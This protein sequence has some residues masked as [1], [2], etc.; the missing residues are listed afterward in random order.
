MY[1]C[2]PDENG[3]IGNEDLIAVLVMGGISRE[4][5]NK[6]FRVLN[7]YT[8]PADILKLPKD[9]R[10]VIG[11]YP[12]FITKDI[13]AVSADDEEPEPNEYVPSPE[14]ETSQ[15]KQEQRV[16][17]QSQYLYFGI[18]FSMRSGLAK[19]DCNSTHLELDVNADGLKAF[20]KGNATFWP[21]L[22]QFGDNY[23]IFIITLYYGTGKPK[24][25]D[26]YLEDFV[27]E[28]EAF[29]LNKGVLIG[30]KRY[31]ISFRWGIFDTPARCFIL[32]VPYY[33]SKKDGCYLCDVKG[34]SLNRR[35][36][37][38]EINSN[39]RTAEDP[40][41]QRDNNPLSKIM[42]IDQTKNIPLDGMHLAE[43]GLM[44]KLTA[45]WYVIGFIFN[46]L[47]SV[48]AQLAR[49]LNKLSEYTPREFNRRISSLDY[50][51]QF[52]SKEFRMLL[53]YM[54][55][56]IFIDVLPRDQYHHFLS[57]HIAY[58]ILNDEKAIQC[59]ENLDFAEEMIRRFVQDFS[60]VYAPEFC[61]FNVHAVLHLVHFVRKFR[62]TVY[63]FSAYPF[64]TYLRQFK[65]GRFLKSAKQPIMQVARRIYEIAVL[66]L[67][68][69]Q[70]KREAR[71]KNVGLSLKITDSEP[72][73]QKFK[74]F[75]T[76]T[77]YFNVSTEANQF[78]E[79][80]ESHIFVLKY[81]IF[82]KLENESYACGVFLNSN[83]LQPLY[84]VPC[85]S[86]CV[87]IHKYIGSLSTKFNVQSV[88]VKRITGKF[89]RLPIPPI[90]EDDKSHAFIRLLHDD[91]RIKHK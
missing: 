87:G 44:K 12:N 14:N 88:N 75:R 29:N 83:N 36:Y 9:F 28:F 25:N 65:L 17:P 8:N 64:E 30:D 74:V 79:I 41:Y 60:K 82:N 52:T 61:A 71:K 35:T 24:N 33:N 11:P 89:F 50:L 72:N 32:G 34:E 53:L 6:I 63:K 10:T 48:K 90:S 67:P 51:S 62:K 19:F 73:T 42:N 43:L 18:E 20:K 5:K 22:G 58:R 84:T 54:G 38:P 76:E 59:D 46:L 21:L 47:P 81:F 2:T 69:K 13:D 45:F 3:Y 15:K 40:L 56:V 1:D 7:H 85:P 31:T 86:D 66:V 78:C 27:G 55:P 37:F 70:R 23:P 26:K 77:L 4:L 80:D 16:I 39:L 68:L 57:L 91:V 49:T